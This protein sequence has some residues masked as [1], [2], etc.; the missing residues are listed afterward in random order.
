M[1]FR[2]Y[3]ALNGVELVNSART[4]AHLGVEMPTTDI[5]YLLSPNQYLFTEDPPGSGLFIPVN[6]DDPPG[7]GLYP[8][9]TPESPAGS[10]LYQINPC[11]LVEVS[12]GLMEL[13][14]SSHPVI[15]D[16]LYSPPDGSVLY[17]RGLLQV[18]SECWIPSEPCGDCSERVAYD[19]SWPGLKDYLHDTNYRV[20]LAPWFSLLKPESKEFMGIWVTDVKGLDPT[21]V[22]RDVTEM[23]GSGGMA[24]PHRDASRTLSFDALLIAC[25]NAGLE[26]G[27]D[28]LAC[29]LRETADRSDSILEFF[30]AHPSYSDVASEEL[31][32]HAHGVVLTQSPQIKESIGPGRRPN[33]QATIYRIS[34][35]MAATNPYVY[36]PPVKVDI[37]WDDIYSQSIQWVHEANCKK[38]NSCEDLPVLF[39]AT[40]VPEVVDVIATPPPACGGCMPVCQMETHFWRMPV[41]LYPV[42]CR[43]T[44][45]TITIRNTGAHELTLQGFWQQCGEDERCEDHLFPFQIAGLPPTGDIVLD[46]ISARYWAF[47]NVD[48]Q[49]PDYVGPTVKVRRKFRPVGIVGTPDGSPWRP[50]VLDREQCWELYITT[51][52]GADFEVSVTLADREP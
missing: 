51:A 34:W 37:D 22:E 38:P 16:L 2:G 44:G 40:C 33:E 52:A 1:P 9:T 46:A 43:D 42:R 7:S 45:V 8:P 13:P 4:V 15:G 19:D 27:L 50:T 3:F 48:F 17:S 47:Y 28:W 24:G 11:Q 29:R 12:R 6:T 31:I 14:D 21:P 20:E 25:T 10:G 5:G 32:R 49:I 30:K 39:S 23:V 18:N 36:L 35:E 41:T 26:Y